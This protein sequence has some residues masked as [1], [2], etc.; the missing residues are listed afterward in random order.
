MPPDWR[1]I[2]KCF[3]KG[4]AANTRDTPNEETRMVTV[5]QD[6]LNQI[7]PELRIVLESAPAWDPEIGQQDIAV[8]RRISNER[9]SA[10]PCFV[11]IQ[12]DFLEMDCKG[13][14]VSAFVYASDQ[15]QTP[16]PCLIWFHGGGYVMGR[17]RD[18]WFSTLFC[19]TLGCTVVSVDYGLAPEKPA[20]AG[21]QDGF[22][23]L[24]WVAEN[25][26]KLGID[27]DRIAIGGLSA[28]GGLAASVAL[29]NRDRNGFQPCLQL[30]LCPM[31]DYLHDT[32]SGRQHGHPIWN[33]KNSIA[34]WK[35]YLG[36]EPT[37][38]TLSYASPSHAKT[39]R[40][41]PPTYMT[42]GEVDLFLDENRKY[43]E[44]LLG[45]GVECEFH[46]FP[47]VFH[48][49]EAAGYSTKI[50]QRM[51]ASHLAALAEAFNL[52]REKAE[53]FVPSQEETTA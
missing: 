38:E 35:L 32:P 43:A 48:A 4:R 3:P 45:A 29:Y 16:S 25:A 39:L 11:D 8:I 44:D 1:D 6:L 17:A 40:G 53:F 51:N 20:P 14:R 36:T 31:L 19:A 37:E 22:A 26:A 50:G 13:H 47:G 9:A 33:R 28:G 18:N 30:L 21:I 23:A 12:P 41:L 34:A 5:E 27:P 49:G 10:S 15:S 24:N 52:T 7:D 42:V 2:R 46:S